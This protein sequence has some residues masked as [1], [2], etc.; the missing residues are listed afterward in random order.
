MKRRY[1]LY[2]RGST[3]YCE[4]TLTGKQET[5]RTKDRETA[6]RLVNARNEAQQQPAINLQIARAYISVSDPAATK[7]ERTQSVDIVGIA[8]GEKVVGSKAKLVVP[9]R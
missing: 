9:D 7:F 8:R 3:W 5:L 2:L 6:L 1:L 4:D